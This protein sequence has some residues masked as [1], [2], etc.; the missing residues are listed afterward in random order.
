VYINTGVTRIFIGI[1]GHLISITRAMGTVPPPRA[2][3]AKMPHVFVCS[4]I[5]RLIIYGDYRYQLRHRQGDVTVWN[6]KQWTVRTTMLLYFWSFFSVSDFR[7]PEAGDFQK[8]I[9]YS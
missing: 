5:V 8:L 9:S 7:D 3:C 6:C 1:S 2:N 4:F